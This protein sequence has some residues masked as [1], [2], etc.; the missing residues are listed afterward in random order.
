MEVKD[1]MSILAVRA[2]AENPE[3]P[4][5]YIEDGLLHCG[6][7][8]TPK[9]C[10]PFPD[11]SVAV[12]CVCRC[13]EQ[14]DAMLRAIRE[15]DEIMR[16]RTAC[17]TGFDGIK[18]SDCINTFS[19]DDSPDSDAAKAV[20]GYVEDIN[21][22]WLLLCGRT[23][24]GKS[25]YAACICNELIDRG[26]SCRFTSISEIADALF[27]A[28]EKSEI[29]AELTRHNLVVLDDLGAERSTEY[30]KEITFRVVDCLIRANIPVVITTNLSPQ[31]M[32]NA[33]D[34]DLQRV[35]SRICKKAIPVPVTG[36]D[37]RRKEMMQSAK[38]RYRKLI[39]GGQETDELRG[40]TEI[41]E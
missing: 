10:R 14:E 22:G 4:E 9:Q 36:D 24:T 15:A 28:E 33:N 25:F 29:Y 8:H 27:A 13:K 32:I 31:E 12:F 41:L 37:R 20:R 26:L 2:E 30:M 19:G 18:K 5:D 6:K 35:Y 34:T 1:Y 39:E 40:Y 7:C 38:S 21:S 16:K 17:F 11:K 3:N 23:G